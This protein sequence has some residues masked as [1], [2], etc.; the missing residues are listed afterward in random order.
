MTDLEVIIGEINDKQLKGLLELFFKNCADENVGPDEKIPQYCKY[1]R[2]I[3]TRLVR[4]GHNESV[5]GWICEVLERGYNS[6]EY[7]D[8][9][10][11]LI[12]KL[13]V[14]LNNPK[15][16]ELSEDTKKDYI[17]GFKQFVEYV[18]GIFYANTW[19][20]LGNEND[21]LFCRLIAENALFVSYD[22]FDKV[23]KGELGTNKNK[24]AKKQS[25]KRKKKGEVGPEYDNKYGSWDYMEHCRNNQAITGRE[26]SEDIENARKVA[27]QKFAEDF[28]DAY[29]MSNEPVPDDNTCA[30]GY[31]KRAILASITKDNLFLQSC[32]TKMFKDYEVCHVWDLPGDRQYYASIANL[33]LVPRALAQLTDHNDAVKNLLRRRAYEFF[34]HFKP[35]GED[36]PDDNYYKEFK[37]LW[38]E[39]K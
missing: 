38:R 8:P 18:V 30:N 23:R 32:K 22:V 9:I 28:P 3:N 6:K 39:I 33:V 35:E 14:V 15:P 10:S 2:A 31:L 4:Q 21:R 20:T 24:K 11:E 29:A 26:L 7:Y 13:R 34:D 19:L 17:C 37:E 25:E 27:N 16:Y 36:V 1:V 5:N 12:N